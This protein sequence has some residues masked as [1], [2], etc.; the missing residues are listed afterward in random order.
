MS[1]T[2]IVGAQWG[3]EGKGKITHAE[4]ENADAVVRYGG[5]ANAGHTL[6]VDGKER[7]TH[8]LPSN[9]VRAEGRAM[10][11]PGV[12][13]DLEV[14]RDEL[15]IA[16][17]YGASVFLDRSAPIVLPIHKLIDGARE[18][19][20]KGGK[21]GTTKRGIGPCYE[22]LVSRRGVKLGDLTSERRL[23]E[24]LTERGYYAERQSVAR[25]HGAEP[26]SLDETVEWCMQ[27]QDDIVPHLADVRHL[28]AQMVQSRR[29][30]LFEGAQG[31]LLDVIQGSRPYCTSSHC[32]AGGA[33]TTMGVYGF[34]RVIGVA[35]AYLTRVGAG[36]FPTEL[37]DGEWLRKKGNEYG[38]TTGRP[39]R[40]GWLDLVALKYACRVGGVTELAITKLDIL[41]G[42]G[43]VYV[44]DRYLF[45][46]KPL[47]KL[48]TLTSRVL[49][50][51]K[52]QLVRFAGWDEDITEVRKIRDLP[53]NARAYIGYIRRYVGVP[54]TMVS[55]GPEPQQVA[56]L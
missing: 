2:V 43:D 29:N 49:R 32:T 34:D 33:S 56:T 42:V 12:V 14:V 45:E 19:S 28:I 30:V 31:V 11:G 8:V 9:I 39:R 37:H 5:G 36:P 4:S 44:S 55:V 1:T 22:D 46:G 25:H 40:C 35:K 52:T 21:L 53:E 6:V 41:S 50:E 27:F 13:H 23:R 15:R 48:E 20:A 47:G 26:M 18:A 17:E 3:D 38:A 24:A 51:S 16:Q 10:T 54:V 7:V